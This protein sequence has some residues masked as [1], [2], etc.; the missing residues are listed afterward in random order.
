M[1]AFFLVENNHEKNACQRRIDVLEETFEHVRKI[2]FTRGPP[3]TF[4]A[5]FGS[6]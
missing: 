4:D 1:F 5:L 3:L 2:G 6:I